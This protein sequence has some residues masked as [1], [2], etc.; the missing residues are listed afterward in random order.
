MK[1]FV[2]LALLVLGATQATAAEAIGSAAA[3]CVRDAS[4]LPLDSDDY[5]VLRQERRR[6]WGHSSTV[7]FVTGLAAAAHRAGAGRLLV[8]DM[9]LAR[10]GPMP[11]GHASHQNGL[12]VDIWFRLSAARLS[13]GELESPKP[14]AMVAGNRVSRAWTPVQAR[15]VELAAR[16][17]EVDRIFINPVI[18]QA[19]CRQA[20]DADR[21]W[22]GKLRPWWGHDEHF[23]VR[24]VCPA[25]SPLC[26]PQKP[27]PEGDGCGA[28]LESWLTKPTSPAPPDR[29]HVQTRAMPEACGHLLAARP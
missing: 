7:D 21:E 12:D 26:E 19:L 13:K 27:I 5:Q 10:G 28:E 15:M 16:A 4:A 24:M 2:A 11:S 22:L 8:A 17:P 14:V 1:L 23:H 29:P 6:F 18:K 3:G 20:P 9:A 25:D